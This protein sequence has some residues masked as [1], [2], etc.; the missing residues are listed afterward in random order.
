MSMIVP[1]NGEEEL[2]SISEQEPFKGIKPKKVR[3]I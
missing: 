2:V 1:S 3:K